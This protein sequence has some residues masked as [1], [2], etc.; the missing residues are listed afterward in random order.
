[1]RD[2]TDKL[3]RL[4]S[5]LSLSMIETQSIDP[6]VN[7][8]KPCLFFYKFLQPIG[9]RKL[10][11]NLPDTVICE[12]MDGG[13]ENLLWLATDDSGYVVHVNHPMTWK[14]KFVADVS[15]DCAVVAVQK[16]PHVKPH[17]PVRNQ[18]SAL[19]KRDI[20]RILNGNT[21]RISY[22]LQK[23]IQCRGAYAAIYRVHWT[24]QNTHNFA[25]NIVNNLKLSDY[26]SIATNKSLETDPYDA[27]VNIANRI[28]PYF[29]ILSKQ[30]DLNVSKVRG[31]PI[32]PVCEAIE[33]IVMHAQAHAPAIRFDEM[34]VDFVKDENGKWWF[35]QVK[36][37]RGHFHVPDILELVREG[38][39]LDSLIRIPS[40]LR[41]KL[42]HSEAAAT[43][44]LFSTVSSCFLCHGPFS[45]SASDIDALGLV[46]DANDNQ[47]LICTC[48]SGYV[49]TLKMASDTITNLLR[50]GVHLASWEGS[51]QKVISAPHAKSS[52][53][54]RVCFVCYQIYKHQ[55][56]LWS[57]A[58]E[59]HNFF[60][61]ELRQ[62]VKR[63]N[64]PFCDRED[65]IVRHRHVTHGIDVDR[66]CQQ[67]CFVFLFH[68]LQDILASEDLTKYHLEYCLG[69]ATHR[70][71]LDGPKTHTSHRWQLSEARVHYVLATDESMRIYCTSK[72]ID[73]YL[74]D[75]NLQEGHASLPLKSLLTTV[76]QS[77]VRSTSSQDNDLFAGGP[78]HCGILVKVKTRNLG[79]LTLKVTLGLCAFPSNEFENLR[80]TVDP[81]DFVQES[82]VFWPTLSYFQPGM[83]LPVEW[84][85]LFGDGNL[86]DQFSSNHNTMM[87]N[88]LES[89]DI[90]ELT[91]S[92]G[93][94]GN[95]IRKHGQHREPQ[96]KPP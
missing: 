30:V 73:I 17:V 63:R 24:P 5:T 58:R 91:I 96:A 37:C 61:P 7:L 84:M 46:L 65:V 2:S 53:E 39:L 72:T 13:Q 59:I 36:A 71:W 76:A 35:L 15:T 16:I 85:T 49:M 32:I 94:Q 19:M 8:I 14:R 50:R 12:M 74:K 70:L 31:Q 21:K 11:L 18:T 88:E 86:F 77:R 34:E 23:Y 93:A 40:V 20:E 9:H 6:F 28:T 33:R 25:L 82:H 4:R 83:I 55:Q 62:S 68:E 52:Q 67:F 81:L 42:P 87:L 29:C 92:S 3:R 48:E 54:I 60:T 26:T 57:T 10:E 69:Q 75:G 47:M 22:G 78:W 66:N 44:P 45:I 64:D 79:H 51:V 27:A 43:I 41:K 90:L 38:D 95:A 89:S 1:M 56:R 80:S